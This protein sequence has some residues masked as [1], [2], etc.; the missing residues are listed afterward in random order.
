MSEPVTPEA[1]EHLIDEVSAFYTERILA[2][3]RAGTLDPERLKVLKESLAACA[4]DRQALQDASEEEVAE[5]AAR[6]AARVKE[7]REE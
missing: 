3:R 7:L 4:A 6:Y 2:A 5:I 1:I